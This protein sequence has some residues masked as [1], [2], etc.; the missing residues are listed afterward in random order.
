M[1]DSKIELLGQ[2]EFPRYSATRVMMMP[3]L[4]EEP[5]GSLPTPLTGYRGL[6]SH[7]CSKSAVREGVGYLTI[8]EA[9]VL[10]G[11]THRR[12]GL[13][14]DGLGAWGGGGG[15]A[16]NGMFVAA[17]V[18]GCEGYQGVFDAALGDD[19]DC[20]HID[21]SKATT[22]RMGASKLYW[23]SPRAIH[24]SLPMP[25]DIHRQ[26]IRISMPS[27]APWH[28]GYTPNPLGIMPTG[29]IGLA[30]PGMSFRVGG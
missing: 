23:C 6:V 30:R 16:A 17:S 21:V 25:R 1:Y 27:D 12:P 10:E 14:V 4:L 5:R 26:F 18:E 15:Y 24:R 20:A 2:V 7:I 28:E 9:L 11:E 13:H 19:G 3:F 29:P 22:V 8:D